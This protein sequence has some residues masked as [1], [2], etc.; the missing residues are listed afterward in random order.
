MPEPKA[1]QVEICRRGDAKP[2]MEGSELALIYFM[3]DK[4]VFTASVRPPGQ[5]SNRDPGQLVYL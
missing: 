3:S 5:K 1:Q 2:L 4:I